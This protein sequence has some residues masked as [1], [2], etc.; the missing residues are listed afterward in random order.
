MLNFSQ[1]GSLMIY[2]I[3]ALLVD[4]IHFVIKTY[5]TIGFFVSKKECPRFVF[6]HRLFVAN[7]LLLNLFFSFR[8]PLSLISGYLR[9]L[10]HPGYAQGWDYKPFVVEQLKH[11]GFQVPDILITIILFCGGIASLNYLIFIYRKPKQGA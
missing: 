4:V 11:L 10:A 8:C 6:I 7:T 5:W 3:L 1:K 9:E 2:T